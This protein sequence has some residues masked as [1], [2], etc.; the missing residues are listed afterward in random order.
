MVYKFLSHTADVKVLV[1]A[2]SLEK[3][4]EDASKALKETV[5]GK[6]KI[7]ELIE[8]EFEVSGKDKEALLYN[9]L[10]EFLFLL[11]AE[12]FLLSRVK[13]IKLDKDNKR[14]KVVATGDKASD[15]GFSND[16]KAITYNEMFVK[17]E[18]KKVKLQFVLDV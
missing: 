11:D 14:L 10:E 3:A 9:F 2:E 16:V 7:K 1:E 5:S 6:I 4:F 13:K 17:E 12:D 18:G 8:Q 15:Y